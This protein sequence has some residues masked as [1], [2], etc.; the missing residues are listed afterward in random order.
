MNDEDSAI[1]FELDK[2]CPLCG[3]ILVSI[4]NKDGTP[5]LGV[6]KYLIF[7]KKCDFEESAD[8]WQER[9]DNAKM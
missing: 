3:G 2:P 9:F 1:D 8:K 4:R 7:C 5:F 6:S